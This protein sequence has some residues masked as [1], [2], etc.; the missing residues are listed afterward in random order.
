M[1]L[2]HSGPVVTHRLA[3][4]AQPAGQQV[5]ANA[6]DISAHAKTRIASLRY[7]IAILP[8]RS[9]SLAFED[10]RA[11][12]PRLA[13]RAK[14]GPLAAGVARASEREDPR[15]KWLTRN[16]KKAFLPIKDY[17]CRERLHRIA[18]RSLACPPCAHDPS[19]RRRAIT[20]LSLAASGRGE[21][22]APIR[23]CGLVAV[24][25]RA[26]RTLHRFP[27]CVPKTL[28]RFIE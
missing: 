7:R 24:L 20:P 26:P 8:F 11:K 14:D 19:W 22:R 2:V 18:R 25:T 3:S 4:G 15:R 21:V 6:G 12:R 10:V 16:F 27:L 23:T 17:P 1:H 9:G 28:S 5:C 13:E